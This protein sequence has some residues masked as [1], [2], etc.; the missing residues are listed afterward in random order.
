MSYIPSMELSF[1]FV[2]CTDSK[3]LTPYDFQSWANRL[4]QPFI[5]PPRNSWIPTV[6]ENPLLSWWVTFRSVMETLGS[7]Y[8]FA[9]PHLRVTRFPPQTFF[10]PLSGQV[11][12]L[13]GRM[14]EAWGGPWFAGSRNTAHFSFLSKFRFE[15]ALSKMLVWIKVKD[16]E[17]QVSVIEWIVKHMKL[18]TWKNLN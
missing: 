14:S 4:V 8:V 18:F 11:D 13:L 10:H 7:I 6:E 9:C 17:D 2:F 16:Q 15:M 3:V 1:T 5:F 12:G